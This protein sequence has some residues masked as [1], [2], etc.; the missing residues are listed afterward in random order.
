MSGSGGLVAQGGSQQTSVSLLTAAYLSSSSILRNS[1]LPGQFCEI[2]FNVTLPAV[3]RISSYAQL[4]VLV[5]ATELVPSSNIACITK[6][7]VT[8][9]FK[10]YNSSYN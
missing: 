1:S 5:P 9:Q 3:R 6:E 4:V 8:C 7:G 2:E 10:T